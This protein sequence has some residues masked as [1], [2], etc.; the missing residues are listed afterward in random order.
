MLAV[1]VEM[2]GGPGAVYA[3]RALETFDQ[4]G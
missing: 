3:A 4:L 1:S 2:A